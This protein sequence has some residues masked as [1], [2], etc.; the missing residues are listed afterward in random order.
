MVTIRADGGPV[1]VA[2]S[3]ATQ[4]TLNGKPARFENL[5]KG[6]TASVEFDRFYN[7]TSL[8]ATG[9]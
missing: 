7:A 3:G 4:I 1:S 2:A 5:Q 8:K 9:K 6:Q